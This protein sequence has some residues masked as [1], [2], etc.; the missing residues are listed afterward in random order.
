MDN[1]KIA[2]DAVIR[3]ASEDE[4]WKDS[5]ER[6]VIVDPTGN[7][8]WFKFEVAGMTTDRGCVL[9]L[10]GKAEVYYHD[11]ETGEVCQACGWDPTV[12]YNSC[13]GYQVKVGGK[14]WDN[15]LRVVQIERVAVHSNSYSDTGCTQTW[16]GTTNGE[17]DTL[18]GSMQ[19]YGRLV[20]YYG[21][22]DAESYEPG[23][24]Y[25][26]VKAAR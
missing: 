16:H 18:D 6:N 15:N 4:F 13:D 10:D 5:D 3:V 9:V 8:I 25:A 21:G 14:F 7:P 23:T 24:N 1:A 11:D 20:R 26:D 2:R 17:Y 12:V 19:P 22:K